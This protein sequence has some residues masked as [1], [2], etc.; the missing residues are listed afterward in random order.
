MWLASFDES[1]EN[2]QFFVYSA[3]LINAEQWNEAF[4]A[5]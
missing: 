5:V 4:E 1:K 2:N 3:L